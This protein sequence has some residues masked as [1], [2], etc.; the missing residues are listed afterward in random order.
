MNQDAS[1]STEM[2]LVSSTLGKNF[3][4]IFDIL[5]KTFRKILRAL[6]NH[7]P[8][9]RRQCRGAHRRQH[10]GARLEE[11]GGGSL[12]WEVFEISQFTY[13]PVEVTLSAVIEKECYRFVSGLCTFIV[14]RSLTKAR[15]KHLPTNQ[16]IQA[17]S[18]AII[19][20]AASEHAAD[21][22]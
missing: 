13:F 3:G 17:K 22:I 14:E 9:P 6:F 15:N 4:K 12:M 21:S 18:Y 7:H 16:S 1:D 8:E 11:G 10:T 5:G 19:A 20:S 2:C